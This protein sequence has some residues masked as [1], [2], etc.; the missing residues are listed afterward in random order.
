MMSN[1]LIMIA[2]MYLALCVG[3]YINLNNYRITLFRHLFFSV[4]S[5]VFVSIVLLFSAVEISKD[6]ELVNNISDKFFL[7]FFTFLMYADAIRILGEL[8]EMKRTSAKKLRYQ[9]PVREYPIQVRRKI[10]RDLM[11]A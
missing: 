5:P 11:T 7:F 8:I 2:V 1:L 10:S 4:T 3:A 9:V 6:K